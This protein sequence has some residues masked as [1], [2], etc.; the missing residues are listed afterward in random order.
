MKAQSHRLHVRCCVI[1]FCLAMV[2]SVIVAHA[3]DGAALLSV[4]VTN[5]TPMLP[6][7][8]FTQTW[9][10]QNTGTTTWSPTYNG[11]TLNLVGADTIGAVPMTNKTSKSYKLTTPIVSGQSVPPGGTAVYAMTFVA[12]EMPGFYTNT[13]QPNNASSVFFGPQVTVLIN[14]LKAG[15]TN[16]YDR[17]RVL[18]YA[19]KYAGYVCSDGYFWTNGSDY[20]HYGAGAAVPTAFLGDDCAHFVSCCIGSET[21]LR[22]GGLPIPIRVPPTYGEPGAAALVNNVLIAPGYAQEVFSLK[23]MEP[24]DV[25]GWNWEG[26]TNIASLDH[27][28]LY[29]GNGLTASHAASCL[30]V[31]ADTWY[32]SSEPNYVRHLVHIFDAPTIVAA[33]SGKNLVMSWG[34]N[35]AGYNLYSANSLSPGATWSKVANSPAK[36][37]RM[38]VLTNSS[39]TGAVFYRLMLP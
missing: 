32:Q 20:Y 7:T 27:V 1:L 19:N 25:I 39:A 36:I 12:P 6:R 31:S 13:F 38:N 33:Q 8:V 28:T 4:T 24:G 10:F 16:Q 29:L 5:N 22:G 37:G 11:Y 9:T 14:V 34:T 15:S 23:D 3:G 26:V 17:A 35:W 30:D 21:N 2:T 18:A